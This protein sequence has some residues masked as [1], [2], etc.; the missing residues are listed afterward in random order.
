[1]M[2]N[3]ATQD[4][5]GYDS[6]T[7]AGGRDRT[8][9]P[10]AKLSLMGRPSGALGVAPQSWS[11]D[12]VSSNPAYGMLGNQVS[13]VKGSGLGINSDGSMNPA[14]LPQPRSWYAPASR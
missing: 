5:S 2:V 9:P 6:T 11:P 4:A 12:S 13:A 10:T 1:M 7:G 3:R 14:Q 8:P